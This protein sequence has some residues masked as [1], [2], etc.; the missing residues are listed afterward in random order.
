MSIEY[1]WLHADEHEEGNH[2]RRATPDG[3]IVAVALAVMLA[4]VSGARIATALRVAVVVRLLDVLGD[5]VRPVVCRGQTIMWA[6]AEVWEG[7][8][9]NDG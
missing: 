4:S 3:V 5:L 8:E 1:L 2:S 6:A 7:G 9:D